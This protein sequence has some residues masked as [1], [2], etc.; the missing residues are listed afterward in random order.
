MIMAAFDA[1]FAPLT[2]KRM[3]IP[4]RFASTSHA[5]GYASGGRVTE[6]Y[7]RYEA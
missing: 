1:M 7:V 2:I 6:R 4:N 3:V 5:P